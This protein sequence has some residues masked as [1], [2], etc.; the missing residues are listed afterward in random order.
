MEKDVCENLVLYII[1]TEAE[2]DAA[3]SSSGSVGRTTES[4]R[5]DLQQSALGSLL[6]PT[7]NEEEQHPAKSRGRK[8]SA[9]SLKGKASVKKSRA[10]SVS[11][12]SEETEQ[13]IAPERDV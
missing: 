10:S 6:A 8:R 7:K 11:A 1:I 3:S 5:T 2:S 9:G 12:E 13:S 4:Q